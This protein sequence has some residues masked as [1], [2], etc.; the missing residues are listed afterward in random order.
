MLEKV[1]RREDFDK[2]PADKIIWVGLPT[3]ESMNMSAWPLPPACRSTP[4]SGR[5]TGTRGPSVS[6]PLE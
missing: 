5:L 4:S 2:I 3:V 6:Y 1:I